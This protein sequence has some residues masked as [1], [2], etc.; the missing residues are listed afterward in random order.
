MLAWE[1]LARKF[2]VVLNIDK[3]KDCN[4]MQARWD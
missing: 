4:A 2:E 3:I 1:S